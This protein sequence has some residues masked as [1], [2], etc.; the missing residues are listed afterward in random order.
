M[1]ISLLVCMTLH[2]YIRYIMSN[3]TGLL[4]EVIVSMAG[5]IVSVLLVFS[6]F[7]L[8]LFSFFLFLRSP[9]YLLAEVS[10]HLS[11]WG[12]RVTHMS[13]RGG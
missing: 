5:I 1:L 6:C 7:F 12:H 4:A 2:T 11:Y 9:C 13:V 8:L 3:S 10:P